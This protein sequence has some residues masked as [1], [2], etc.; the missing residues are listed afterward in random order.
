LTKGI[1]IEKQG[2]IDPLSVKQ[3]HSP[4]L[5]KWWLSSLIDEKEE[6]RFLYSDLYS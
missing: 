6:C 4:F 2:Y 1:K 3:R 5:M